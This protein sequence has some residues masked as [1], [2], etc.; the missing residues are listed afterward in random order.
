MEFDTVMIHYAEIGIKGD[1][2]GT[3][4]RL[5]IK[6]ITAK[7][8]GLV[9]AYNRDFGY[10]IIDLKPGADLGKLK[11]ILARI[12]GI[13]SFSF[14][15]ACKLNT[16]EI[17]KCAVAMLKEKTFTGFKVASK[18]YNKGFNTGSLELNKELGGIILD[19]YD[20]KVNLHTP[21]IIVKVEIATK[22]AYVSMEEIKGVGGLPIN[23]RQKVVV[24]LSGGFDS[25][26]AAYM[27]MKRGCEVILVHCHNQNLA[28]YSVK[29]KIEHLAQC[30]SDF[31]PKTRL[32]MVPFEKIQK[33][34]IINANSRIRMLVY[35]RFMLKIAARI[36]IINKAKFIVVGDSMSQVA[37]QTIEN[38]EATYIGSEKPILTPLIGMDKQ[39]IINI[40]SKIG[41]YEI[42][43]Q[44]YGDCCSYFLPK[45]PMLK[46]NIAMLMGTEK[47]FDSEK[48]VAEAVKN[49]EVRQ[50]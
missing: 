37:S 39:E 3:F 8:K 29:D 10:I 22:A 7:A 23:P 48:L 28:S 41:T 33:E 49:A 17:G 46:G 4:E 44:P 20:K 36:A 24:L 18:R 38:L 6:N 32:F 1:N 19:N 25:P 45:H 27:M 34:I 12:P 2:R 35:R 40:A 16:N 43:K 13:S 30:L 26:V 15:A 14:A 21:D 50:F 47:Q 42:S 31:Q 9:G 5:L 11:T